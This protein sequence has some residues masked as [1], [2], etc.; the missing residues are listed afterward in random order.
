MDMVAREVV[1]IAHISLH[2]LTEEVSG[3]MNDRV[4]KIIYHLTT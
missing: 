3:N 1:Q 2:Q 4:N